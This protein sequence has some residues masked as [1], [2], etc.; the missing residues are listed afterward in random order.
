MLWLQEDFQ[1]LHKT[2]A[3]E[4]RTAEH[5]KKHPL[6]GCF[7]FM[8]YLADLIAFMTSSVMSFVP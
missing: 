1:N 6:E 7:F 3:Q 2:P 4:R 8:N 5:A